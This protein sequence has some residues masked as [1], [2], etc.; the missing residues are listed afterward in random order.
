MIGRLVPNL[1]S[2]TFVIRRQQRYLGLRLPKPLLGYAHAIE[3]LQRQDHHLHGILVVEG[4]IDYVLARQ[5]ALP[6]VPVALLSTHPSR[7]QLAEL[8]HL[9]TISGLPILDWHDADARGRA[10]ALHLLD[11]LHGYKCRMIPE[12][13]GIKDLADLALHPLGLAK[14][15]HAWQGMSDGDPL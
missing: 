7:A 14:L 13:E 8:L 5:W 1:P 2:Q 12:M 4:A 9:Q 6:A 15:A 10:S 3:H 11:L